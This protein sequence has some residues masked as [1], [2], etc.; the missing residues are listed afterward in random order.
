MGLSIS[1]LHAYKHGVILPNVCTAAKMVRC[2][3]HSFSTIL[4]TPSCG[5]AP[6]VSISRRDQC[7]KKNS[8]VVVLPDLLSW[9]KPHP[10]SLRKKPPI[11]MQTKDTG[12][13][14]SR[15]HFLSFLVLLMIFTKPYLTPCVAFGPGLTNRKEP[16]SRPRG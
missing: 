10:G 5:F 8:L 12:T 1:A 3:I 6:F 15:H 2:T 7:A 9:I 14:F 11:L 13:N 4:P 16:L